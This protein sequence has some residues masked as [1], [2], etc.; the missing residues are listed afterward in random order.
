MLEILWYYSVGICYLCLLKKLQIIF[1]P[2]TIILHNLVS[3]YSTF[4]IVK[5]EKQAEGEVILMTP[6]NSLLKKLIIQM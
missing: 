4:Y 3:I 1:L 2:Q 5:G 6:V